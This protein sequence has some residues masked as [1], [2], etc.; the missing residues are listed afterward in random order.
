MHCATLTQYSIS[1]TF[2]FYCCSMSWRE[3]K[4]I[5]NWSE[6]SIIFCHFLFDDKVSMTW[7]RRN[8]NSG[9]QIIDTFILID[10]LLSEAVAQ[11]CSVK[12]VFLEIS[13]NSQENICARVSFLGL[14][15][16][17][18]GCFWINMPYRYFFT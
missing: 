7:G 5:S 17:S 18:G 13:Q 14:A 6:A 11:R 9:F 8:L 2:L 12:Q 16:L 4:S 15:G 10:L 1:F 3:C